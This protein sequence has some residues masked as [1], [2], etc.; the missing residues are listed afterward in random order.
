M[1]ESPIPELEPEKVPDFVPDFKEQKPK[2]TESD[3]L[4]ASFA[5]TIRESVNE[6]QTALPNPVP[7]IT[8]AT[9]TGIIEISFSEQL[10]QIPAEID[11]SKLKYEPSQKRR[12]DLES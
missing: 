11:I 8:K 12:R 2:Q 4:T 9:Q 1:P 7:S 6:D 5:K 10:K 3:R